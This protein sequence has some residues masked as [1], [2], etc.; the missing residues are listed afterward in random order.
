M[1]GYCFLPSLSDGMPTRDVSWS[2]LITFGWGHSSDQ[3][4]F[5]TTRH[6]HT[7]R[8]VI[9]TVE[10]L[11]LVNEFLGPC[12]YLCCFTCSI[13]LSSSKQCSV[14]YFIRRGKRYPEIL[15]GYDVINGS[16]IHPFS[17]ERSD[18]WQEYIITMGHH[19]MMH[20]LDIPVF[21]WC[22]SCLG[23]N[24]PRDEFCWET[25]FQS[26][27]VIKICKIWEECTLYN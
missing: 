4:R 3:I 15:D 26:A 8:F 2:L 25:G 13:V 19:V 14:L 1:G 11:V 17:T 7:G 16:P 27:T 9:D 5:S 10:W 21:R 24:S 22:I 18:K 20:C 23:P 12:N 6:T